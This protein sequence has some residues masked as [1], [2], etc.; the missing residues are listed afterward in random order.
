MSPANDAGRDSSGNDAGAFIAGLFLG[1]LGIAILS[2]LFAPRC[3]NC[4]HQISR[5][6]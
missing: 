3:P 2:S 6:R 5:G 4:N 1:A